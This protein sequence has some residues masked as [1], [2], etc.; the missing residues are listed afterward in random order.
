MTACLWRK[1]TC[2]EL[3]DVVFLLPSGQS[4][5]Q[6]CG[7]CQSGQCKAIVWVIGDGLRLYRLREVTAG[8][9]NKGSLSDPLRELLRDG[10][11]ALQSSTALTWHYRLTISSIAVQST[12][13][14]VLVD[15]GLCLCILVSDKCK[16]NFDTEGKC[17]IQ[18]QRPFLNMRS[19]LYLWTCE[20]CSNSK[21]TSS[22]VQ[23]K[24]PDV[25]L[26][27]PFYGGCIKR[28]LV[29]TW[30]SQVSQNAFRT[31]QRA[32]MAKGKTR[33]FFL[34]YCY[35]VMKCSSKSISGQNVVV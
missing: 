20:Y 5:C 22:Q 8:H 3:T 11:L 7:I 35:C 30:G 32:L 4:R 31:N 23:A 26:L 28:W 18:K 2:K 27:H 1:S 21:F 12:S 6:S 10:Q 24:S 15:D 19:C 25:F 17:S 16:W 14:H 33:T 13:Q 34:Y 9:V 29:W